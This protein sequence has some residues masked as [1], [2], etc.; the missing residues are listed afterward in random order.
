[1]LTFFFPLLLLFWLGLLT[2]TKREKEQSA[3]ADASRNLTQARADNGQLQE[4]VARLRKEV[5]ALEEQNKLKDEKL[6]ANVV[7]QEKMA[8]RVGDLR[9][10][11]TQ[12]KLNAKEVVGPANPASSVIQAVAGKV[13]S[14]LVFLPPFFVLFF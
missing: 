10:E 13:C 5:E 14:L 7:A 12:L 2:K 1:L 3:L 11:L 6:L 8:Q 9:Q 4:E